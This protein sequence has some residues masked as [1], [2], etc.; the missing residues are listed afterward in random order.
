MSAGWQVGD[1]AVCTRPAA[2][3][4][5]VL[6]CGLVEGPAKNGVYQVSQVEARESWG[7][8]TGLRFVE[9][10][11]AYHSKFF[12]KIRPDTE[13]CEAEFTTLIKRGRKVPA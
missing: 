1:L 10:P 9:F 3:W 12:R 4:M 7:G 8:E 13:P 5:G 6:G 11:L 2:P